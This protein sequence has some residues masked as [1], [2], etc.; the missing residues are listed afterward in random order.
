MKGNSVEQAVP[1]LVPLKGVSMYRD[2]TSHDCS[3]RCWPRV[4]AREPAD[5]GEGG[6]G[7]GGPP[8]PVA[9]V[10]LS[11]KCLPL[12]TAALSKVPGKPAEHGAV[13]PS[14]LGQLCMAP[15]SNLERSC[16]RKCWCDGLPAVSLQVYRTS[17]P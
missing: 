6:D 14:G 4:Q 1:P 15:G 7:Q 3:G 8:W 10:K 12:R 17:P 11:P 2:V 9:S 5:T 16:L 13:V